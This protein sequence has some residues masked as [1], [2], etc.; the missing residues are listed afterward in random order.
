MPA[1]SEIRAHQRAVDDL[2][3]LSLAELVAFWR[4]LD[5]ADAAASTVAMREFLPALFDS[6]VPMSAELGALFYD[7]LRAAANADG[8]F[9]AEH[10][11]GPAAGRVQAL[12]G[13][14]MAPLF[15]E[16]PDAA[17][18][19]SLLSGGVQR[20]V[21][22]GARET[23]AMNA[24]GD[25]VGTT[26]ARHASANA[27]AFC[28]LLATRGDAYGSKGAAERV[29]GRGK[30]P[31]DEIVGWRGKQAKGVKAR[32]IQS[33]GHKYHDHCHCVAVPVF[34]GEGYE[35]APYVKKWEQAYIQG[36]RETPRKASKTRKGAESSQIDIDA[37][38]AHMRQNLGVS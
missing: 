6:Y 25:P 2:A 26:Y 38:L 18:A 16:A 5:T 23:V 12:T 21:S 4:T 27:C 20:I 36:V 35:P 7:D 11:P 1:L 28:A 15:R 14:G 37:V 22:D 30:T 3:T 32:G 17:R 31:A 9:L 33:L 13:W 10:A 19:L 8:V 29:V 34:P 24:D